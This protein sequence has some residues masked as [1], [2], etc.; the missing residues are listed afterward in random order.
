MDSPTQ[1]LCMT[2]PVAISSK[3][4]LSLLTAESGRTTYCMKKQTGGAVLIPTVQKMN[5]APS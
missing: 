1:K 2:I 3:K 4:N 5:F